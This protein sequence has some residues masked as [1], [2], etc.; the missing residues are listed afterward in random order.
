LRHSFAA[1]LLSEKTPLPVI[2]E[3]LGHGNTNS[4]MYYLSI[5]V[6]SLKQC[7]LDVPLVPLSFYIQKGGLSHE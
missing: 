5:D 3:A 4:T 7:A 1:N 6:T 2:S